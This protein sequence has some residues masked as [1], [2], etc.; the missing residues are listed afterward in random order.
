MGI[1]GNLLWNYG[2]DQVSSR[3]SCSCSYHGFKAYHLLNWV[4]VRNLR[5][6]P[7]IGPSILI[8][9]SVLLAYMFETSNHVS[10]L[11]FFL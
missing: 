7:K 1:T 9:L 2:S 5:D 6:D 11:P 8:T 4:R 10:L 3:C